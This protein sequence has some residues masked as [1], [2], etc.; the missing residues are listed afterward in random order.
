MTEVLL[1]AP[2]SLAIAL[3]LAAFSEADPKIAIKRGLKTWAV[4]LIG[5]AA[6]GAL[7]VIAQKPEILLG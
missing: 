2:A 3:A 4:L 5:G 1:Y 6:F 7:I